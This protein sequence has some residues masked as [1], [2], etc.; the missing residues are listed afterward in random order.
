MVVLHNYYFYPHINNASPDNHE[1][2]ALEQILPSVFLLKVTIPQDLIGMF[3][4][5]VTLSLYFGQF[6]LPI[7]LY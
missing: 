6:T 2:H 7:P 4:P 5:H 3:Y 1:H